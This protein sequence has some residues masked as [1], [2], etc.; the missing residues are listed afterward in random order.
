MNTEKPTDQLIA[1]LQ[2]ENAQLKKSNTELQTS[3]ADLA[4]KHEALEARV[5]ALERI[6][7]E[8]R[9]RGIG[10]DCIG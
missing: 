9:L 2:Q 6:N 8:A 4:K 5:L 1:E 10:M 7:E 3:N